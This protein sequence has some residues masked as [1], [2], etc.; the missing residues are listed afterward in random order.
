MKSASGES[1]SQT[2]KRMTHG[3]YDAHYTLE[4]MSRATLLNMR[5]NKRNVTCEGVLFTMSAHPDSP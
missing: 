5:A 4:P 2:H 3:W 1:R